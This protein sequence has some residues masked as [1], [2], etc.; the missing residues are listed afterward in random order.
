MTH[1]A[2]SNFVAG[3]SISH[4]AQVFARASANW[5]NCPS[6]FGVDSLIGRHFHHGY[7]LGLARI[8]LSYVGML[9]KKRPDGC[10]S[11]LIVLSLANCLTSSVR[12]N[13]T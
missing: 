5:W 10:P 9:T 2:D 7:N 4:E 11:P 1:E 6:L 8:C 12:G 13:D 3:K